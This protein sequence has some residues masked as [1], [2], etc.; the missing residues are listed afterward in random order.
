MRCRP[1]IAVASEIDSTFYCVSSADLVSSWVGESERYRE[2]L[3]IILVACIS[4]LLT[5]H[6]D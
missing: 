3:T 2:F 4:C 1:F 5:F 6:L